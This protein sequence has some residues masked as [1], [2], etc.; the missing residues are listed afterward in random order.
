MPFDARSLALLAAGGAVGT[1]A[2]A[3][4]SAWAAGRWGSGFPWGTLIVNAAGCFAIGVLGTLCQRGTLGPEVRTAAVV[5][6]LG[7]F[8]TFSAFSFESWGLVQAG[9][10]AG[11]LLNVGLGLGAGFAALAAGVGVARALA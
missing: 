2:R 7:A 9:N 4:V 1:L 3:G 11:A 6:L 8:T 10:W 5:G